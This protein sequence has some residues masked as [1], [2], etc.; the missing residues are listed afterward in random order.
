MGSW[1]FRFDL[2]R[3]RITISPFLTGADLTEAYL[4]GANLRGANLTGAIG[5]QRES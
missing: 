3:L 5:Y 2:S 4:T 1:R